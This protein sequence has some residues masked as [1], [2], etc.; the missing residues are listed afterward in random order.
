MKSKKIS[1]ILAMSLV[2]CS[3]CGL[4]ANAAMIKYNTFEA[5]GILYSG[6]NAVT[7]RTSAYDSKYVVTAYSEYITSSTSQG[8]GGTFDWDYTKAQ[9]QCKTGG[10]SVYR[11]HSTHAI[12]LSSNVYVAKTTQ[13]LWSR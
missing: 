3:I 7:T 5:N 4:V 6:G 1:K 10:G 9:A 13:Y 11:Y 8:Y 2:M 12:A